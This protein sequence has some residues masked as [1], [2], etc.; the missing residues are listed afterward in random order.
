MC[1]N[2]NYKNNV[3]NNRVFANIHLAS[4]CVKSV[5]AS[6]RKPEECLII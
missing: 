4:D 6:L 5:T 1:K 2:N 3:N